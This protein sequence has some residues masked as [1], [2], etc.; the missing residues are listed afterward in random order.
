M[1][2]RSSLHM[3]AGRAR[4][5]SADCGRRVK[6]IAIAAIPMHERQ[7]TLRMARLHMDATRS[8][9]MFAQRMILVEGVSTRSSSGN[10]ARWAQATRPRRGSWTR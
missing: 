8:A 6:H 3:H 10:W 7:R 1:Q 9:S 5:A 4:R 2:A